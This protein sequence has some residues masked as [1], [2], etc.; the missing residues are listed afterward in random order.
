MKVTCKKAVEMSDIINIIPYT[1]LDFKLLLWTGYL[2]I[3]II[4]TW[5]KI[6]VNIFIK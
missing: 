4:N 3:F 2:F 5:H 1:T 6:E